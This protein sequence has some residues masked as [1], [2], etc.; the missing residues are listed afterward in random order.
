MGLRLWTSA[1][2]APPGA[3]LRAAKLSNFPLQRNFNLGGGDQ[4]VP[5]PA[6]RQAGPGSGLQSI[7]LKTE[8]P[9]AGL[10]QAMAQVR[11]RASLA[12]LATFDHLFT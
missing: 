5:G 3:S 2:P 6:Y 12:T 1:A 10:G 8:E 9:E 11:P 4:R 7:F